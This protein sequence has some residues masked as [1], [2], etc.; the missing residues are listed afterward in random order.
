MVNVYRFVN[1]KPRKLA[2]GHVIREGLHNA[3]VTEFL[4]NFCKENEIEEP[5]KF[6][7]M[8]ITDLEILHDGM[9]VGLG[10][11]EAMFKAWRKGEAANANQ[12]SR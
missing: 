12:S 5:E 4:T 8:T 3:D 11:T 1:R 2:M 9:I 10:I 6:I 7:A